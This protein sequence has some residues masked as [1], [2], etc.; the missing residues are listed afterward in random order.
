M[1]EEMPPERRA[2]DRIAA[3][4][5]NIDT[6]VYIL[7]P[8][9]VEALKASVIDVVALNQQQAAREQQLIDKLHAC[10]LA[11][12]RT[13][14]AKSIEIVQLQKDLEAAKAR[15]RELDQRTTH[16]FI[17]SCFVLV[18]IA[19]GV[20]ILTG[21]YKQVIGGVIVIIGL[22]V[23]IAGYLMTKRAKRAG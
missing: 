15:I 19:I 17:L 14:G 8:E 12:T 9:L 21:D 22:G 2:A 23:Q 18:L 11:N 1:A 10:R 16:A 13:L 5:A 4:L 7:T 20:N 3:N 6:S